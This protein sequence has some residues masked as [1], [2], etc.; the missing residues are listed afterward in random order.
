MH[1]MQYRIPLPSDYDMHIIRQRVADKG[2]ALDNFPGL[3]LKAYLIRE[4][5]NSE[6]PINEYAPFYL[7]SDIEAM[8]QFLYGGIGF[9]GI[10]DSFGRPSVIHGNGI[11]AEA[12]PQTGHDP[13]WATLQ[14]TPVPAH[15]DPASHAADATQRAQDLT[16]DSNTHTI[17]VS[18]NPTNWTLSVFTLYLNQPQP[19]P[20]VECFEVLHLSSPELARITQKDPS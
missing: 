18:I 9:G 20:E 16:S 2:T 15:T 17:A 19:Q 4:T 3:G 5:H 6:S 8:K 1:S 10:I 11:A 7:W 14:T 12:G 13:R